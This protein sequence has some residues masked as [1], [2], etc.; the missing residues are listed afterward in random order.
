MEDKTA[1][2][3]IDYDCDEEGKMLLG[4]VDTKTYFVCDAGVWREATIAEEQAGEACTVGLEGRFNRDSTRICENKNFREANLYDFD[5]GVKN[6]FNPDV[7]Y[8]T[9]EDARDGRTYKTVTINGKTVMAENLNYADEGTHSYLIGKNWCYKNDTT[10][11]LKGG[12]YYTWTAAMDIDSKWQNALVPADAIKTPHQG[13]CPDGWHIPKGDEWSA[14]F[15]GI[16]YA[17]QQAMGNVGWPNANNASGF[18]ALP[19]G[20]FSGRIIQD[21]IVGFYAYFWSATESSSDYVYYWRMFPSSSSLEKYSK[22][23][24]YPVRCFKD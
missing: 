5:V 7:Q 1:Y 19:V 21:G 20:S 15:S 17:K 23:L 9:L 13:I 18:S 11:C 22:D 3:T 2:N 8:G 4:L 16:D 14:L 10:N 24:A 12:R 6:Y